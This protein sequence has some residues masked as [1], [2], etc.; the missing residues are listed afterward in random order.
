MKGKEHFD[1]LFNLASEL[2]AAV[3]ASRAACDAG[4][5]SGDLQI[6]QTGKTIAPVSVRVMI[7]GN[8]LQELY[9]GCGI[10]GA[11]QHI[12]GM[13]DS[14]VIVVINKDPEAPFFECMWC[15]LR[16]LSYLSVADYGLKA[17]LF[18]AVPEM[19]QALKA[20]K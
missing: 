10:S 3:G 4:Y 17:D 15:C 12:A 1:I 9:I 2:D 19:T 20:A 8:T 7:C 6:G 5:C 14:K 11:A 13:K 16:L 18:Q